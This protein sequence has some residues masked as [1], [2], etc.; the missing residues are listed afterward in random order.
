MVKICLAG[1]RK[2]IQ[3][4]GSNDGILILLDI[5]MQCMNVGNFLGKYLNILSFPGRQNRIFIQPQ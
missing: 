2:I 4:D 1:N 3:D 5:N